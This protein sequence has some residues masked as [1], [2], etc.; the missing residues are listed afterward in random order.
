MG[1]ICHDT[2]KAFSVFCREV[3]FGTEMTTNSKSLSK[4]LDSPVLAVNV[5]TLMM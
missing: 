4:I 5:K 3:N 2:S 1:H